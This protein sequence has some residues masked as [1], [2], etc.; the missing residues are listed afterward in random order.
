[1]DGYRDDPDI[2]RLA[3]EVASLEGSTP[4]DAVRHALEDR[5]AALS[6][7]GAKARRKDVAKA[8]AAIE[9][10]QSMPIIDPRNHDEIMY[11]ENGLPR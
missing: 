2:D 11:D 9:A 3:R 6:R 5:R 7:I 10:L 8:R 4:A 1:M